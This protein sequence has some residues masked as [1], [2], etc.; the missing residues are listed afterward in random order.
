MPQHDHDGPH[1]GRP[2]YQPT[3]ADRNTVKSMAACGMTHE[4]IARC[5]GTDGIHPD[6]MRVHFRR[7]LDTSMDMANARVGSVVF[8]RA[9]EGDGWACCFWLKCRAGWKETQVT[10]MAGSLHVTTGAVDI[11]ASRIAGIAA[12]ST[13]G[14]GDPQ[15]DE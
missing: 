10:E 6:T 8:A 9:L 13:A 4:A 12:K 5:L 14:S 1:P 2:P 11:L 3:E 15:P 7:E